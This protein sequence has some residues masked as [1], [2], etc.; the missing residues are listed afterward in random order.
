MTFLFTEMP[1]KPIPIPRLLLAMAAAF[2]L[3][4]YASAADRPN[5]LFVAIDDLNDWVGPLGGHPQVQTPHMDALAA[6]GTTFTNAHCQNPL[7][8]PSRTSV[9]TGLRPTTTGIYGLTPWFRDLPA[10]ADIPTLPQHFRNHGYTTYTT[11]KIFHGGYGREK[12]GPDWDVVGPPTSPSPFP[13]ERLVNGTPSPHQLVD[14][15]FFPHRDEDKGDYKVA[16]WAIEQLAAMPDDEP[17]FLATGFFLPHVPCFATQKWFDLYPED[18]LAL[19]P[20]R[21]DDRDDTPRASWWLHWELPE[22]RLKFLQEAGEWKNLV[23][24]YLACI[25][26]VDAQLGRL[27]E[28]L[29]QSGHADNTVVVLWSDHGFHLGEKL[30]TGKNTLWERSTRVPLI[31]AGPGVA[32][33]SRCGEAVE[34]L[35]LFP[36][37]CD[38][39]ALPHPDGLEGHSLVPQLGDPTA[40]RPWPAITNHNPGNNSVRTKT[41]RYIRYVDG[42]EELYDTDG[43]PH[44]FTNLAADTAHTE[45]LA[46]LRRWIPQSQATHA[47]NSAHRIL[48]Y[49]DAQPVWEGNPIRPDDPVPE[50]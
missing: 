29:E 6:R 5:I 20:M 1:A 14:W 26:F 46:E 36:T 39:A 17:F 38:L 22:P 9:L 13:D 40:A 4:P 43:D 37:L 47:P 42:S 25:S 21:P 23:R 50:L 27:L 49:K 32:P 24:S 41:W 12:G 19:P 30:I 45:T 48:E 7:C 15:G 8:N 28:A 16:T 31:F 18:S 3:I 2:L 34:L 33:G 10:L 35:D 11:G 44:E